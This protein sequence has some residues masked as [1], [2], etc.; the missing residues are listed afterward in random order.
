MSRQIY[1]FFTNLQRKW[2][3]FLP[4]NIVALIF[5]PII[6]NMYIHQHNFNLCMHTRGSATLTEYRSLNLLQFICQ[7]SVKTQSC[8]LCD[9]DWTRS[10]RTS[11]FVTGI[12]SQASLVTR[13]NSRR[14]NLSTRL[15][16][17]AATQPHQAHD[18]CTSLHLVACKVRR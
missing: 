12:Q 3:Q 4:N 16:H 14:Q 7:K 17:S 11:G 1:D 9:T 18:I 8:F 5:G 2:M 10:V 6:Q 13:K 15:F